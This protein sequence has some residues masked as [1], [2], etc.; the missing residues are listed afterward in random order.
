[1]ASAR[2]LMPL[3]I[4]RSMI[5]APGSLNRIQKA[6]AG[7]S[8]QFTRHRLTSRQPPGAGYRAR[9]QTPASWS[10]ATKKRLGSTSRTRGPMPGSIRI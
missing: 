4:L 1:M 8:G 6:V 10:P 9:H 5:K 7:V 2:D 3:S